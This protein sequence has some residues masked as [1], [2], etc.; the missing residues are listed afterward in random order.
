[1]S[2]SSSLEKS[3]GRVWVSIF[4]IRSV[5]VADKAKSDDFDL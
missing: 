4:F 2:S 3:I 5:S 1:M